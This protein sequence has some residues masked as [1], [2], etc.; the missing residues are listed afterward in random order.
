MANNKQANCKVHSEIKGWVGHEE[1]AVVLQ[2]KQKKELAEVS[3]KEW[4]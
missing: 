2:G 4:S 1:Q 3:A